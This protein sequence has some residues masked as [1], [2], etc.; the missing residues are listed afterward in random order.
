LRVDWTEGDPV[1]EL[2]SIWQLYAPQIEAYVQRALDP[3]RAPSFGV[4]GDP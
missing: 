2:D 1:A 4:P 3:T